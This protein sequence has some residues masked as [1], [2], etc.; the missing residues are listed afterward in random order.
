MNE[1]DIAW[2][3]EE[4]KIEKVDPFTGSKFSNSKN[5]T[6]SKPLDRQITLS[7]SPRKTLK[8]FLFIALFGLVFFAGRFSGD[9]GGFP[10]S[11]SGLF[12]GVDS[13]EDVAEPESEAVL[14]E[15]EAAPTEEVVPEVA[16][17]EKK[18]DIDSQD[19]VTTYNRVALALEDRSI[20]WKETWG[21]ITAIDITIKNS[22]LGRVEPARLVMN[23]EGYNDFDKEIPLPLELKKIGMSTTLRAKLFVPNGFAYNEVSTGPLADVMI[24]LS[25]YDD[26]GK[27]MSRI[28]KPI[29]LQG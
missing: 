16:P 11:I 28:Q 7:L 6:K 19:L 10:D 4:K 8:A 1:K 29:S 22:E 9:I 5:E 12:V 25:L 24:T 3:G 15:L 14:A 18:V 23:V 13:A 26:F 21:K 27:L 2:P 20:Q 17:E